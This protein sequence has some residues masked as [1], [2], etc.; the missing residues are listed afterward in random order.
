[1]KLP[2]QKQCAPARSK[3]PASPTQG[4]RLVLQCYAWDNLPA[5]TATDV[6]PSAS[7]SH[8][9]WCLHIVSVGRVH[10][11]EGL[12][13]AGRVLCQVSRTGRVRTKPLAFWANQRLS[14]ET[15]TIDQG[16]SDQ[17][18]QQCQ[19]F[20]QQK[21]KGQPSSQGSPS[22]SRKQ[23]PA[24][25]KNTNGKVQPR[26][27]PLSSCIMQYLMPSMILLLHLVVCLGK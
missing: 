27:A 17:L 26:P 23:K 13:G 4:C 8:G 7:Q 9:Q 20:T 1:M 22:G 11:I 12:K 21:A 6:S 10:A 2:K 25:Q 16:F 15:G 14:R 5:L 19:S 24:A 18:A 3:T